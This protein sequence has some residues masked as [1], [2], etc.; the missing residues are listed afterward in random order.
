MATRGEMPEA[1]GEAGHCAGTILS[2]F[3]CSPLTHS[4]ASRRACGSFN[5]L[6][7]AGVSML[8]SQTS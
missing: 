5:L 6:E 4:G 3:P 7:E 8:A 2:P 1:E